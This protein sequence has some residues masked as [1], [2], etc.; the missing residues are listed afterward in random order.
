MSA[1]PIFYHEAVAKEDFFTMDDAVYVLRFSARCILFLWERGYIRGGKI[2]TCTVDR[3]SVAYYRFLRRDISR[4]NDIMGA[5]GLHYN[6]SQT[7]RWN[8]LMEVLGEEAEVAAI[9]I[10]QNQQEAAKIDRDAAG[11]IPVELSPWSVTKVAAELKIVTTRVNELIDLGHITGTRYRPQ[12]YFRADAE[13][14]E[15]ISRIFARRRLVRTEWTIVEEGRQ[16]Y[17]RWAEL[18]R[19][20]EEAV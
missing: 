9:T 10:E 4:V 19:A 1:E 2:S 7:Q 18:L 13:S 12:I 20:I 16:G 5:L 11:T 14:V 17:V 3:R 15:R 6:A 8:R